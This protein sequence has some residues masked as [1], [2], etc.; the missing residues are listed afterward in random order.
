VFTYNVVTVQDGRATHIEYCTLDG[1]NSAAP[2][3][4]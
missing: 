1:C 4:L 3:V 2:E